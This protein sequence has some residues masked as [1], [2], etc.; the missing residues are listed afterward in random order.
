[1]EKLNGN[2]N[3]YKD[4]IK[5]VDI[6]ESRNENTVGSKRNMR[7]AFAEGMLSLNMNPCMPIVRIKSAEERSRDAWNQTGRSFIKTGNAI[8]KAIN[9]YAET[10]SHRH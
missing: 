2:H 9:D 4:I 7:S 10:E 3:K 8:E 5:N 1:M 6:S